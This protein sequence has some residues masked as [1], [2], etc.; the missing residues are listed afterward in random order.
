MIKD[1][2]LIVTERAHVPLAGDFVG[3]VTWELREDMTSK[4]SQLSMYF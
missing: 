4:S 2:A 3:A 1:D